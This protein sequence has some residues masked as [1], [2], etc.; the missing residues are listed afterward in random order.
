MYTRV[1][2]DVSLYPVGKLELDQLVPFV[3]YLA[4]QAA[5]DG[6]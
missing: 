6:V 1:P 5:S 2:L 3:E 4:Y